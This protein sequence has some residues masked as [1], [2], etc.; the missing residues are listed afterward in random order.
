ME[1][2]A[3]EEQKFKNKNT[4]NF[5]TNVVYADSDSRAVRND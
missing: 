2:A 5:W 3:Y 1:G 4:N